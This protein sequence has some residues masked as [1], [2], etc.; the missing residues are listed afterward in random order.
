[1]EEGRKR[2]KEKERS[3]AEGRHNAERKKTIPKAKLRGYKPTRYCNYIYLNQYKMC[4]YVLHYIYLS[5][6][7]FYIHI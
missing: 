3:S 1:M 2:R 6:N 4:T 5:I 7:L